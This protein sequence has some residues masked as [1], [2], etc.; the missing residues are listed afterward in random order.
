MPK[1]EIHFSSDDDS[2]AKLGQVV[3]TF[4]S[5]EGISDDPASSEFTP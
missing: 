1:K 3:R 2:D 4:S 5:S